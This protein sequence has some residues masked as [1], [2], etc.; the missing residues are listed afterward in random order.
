MRNIWPILK[1][2]AVI[3]LRLAAIVFVVHLASAAYL[4]HLS[5]GNPAAAAYPLMKGDPE[6]YAALARNLLEHGVFSDSDSLV[7]SRAWPPAY[8]A[9]L[10][11]SLWATGS[12]LPVVALQIALACA[13]AAL[14]FRMALSLAPPRWAFAAALLF[15]AEPSFVLSN[16]LLLT[17]GL[18]ASLL[19]CAVYL[20]LFAD[21]RGRE[22][23]RWVFAGAFLGALTLLRPIAEFLIP[24][25]AVFML[26]E[27]FLLR[28]SGVRRAALHAIALL[29][30]AALVLAP[31][32]MRNQRL[33]GNAEIAHVGA[34]NLLHYNAREFLQWQRMETWSPVAALRAARSPADPAL[35]ADVDAELARM[36]PEGGA[37][38]DY[39]GALAAR[40]ILARPFAYAYFHIVNTAPF[41]VG[42]G[43]AAYAQAARQIGTESGFYAPTSAALFAAA[44][45]AA[46][47][48]WGGA[49]RRA[50]PL[51]PVIL[52]MLFWSAAA[53]LAAWGAWRLRRDSRAAA[54][55]LIVL[56]FALITGPVAIPRY[57]LP[58]EPFLLALAAAG[59]SALAARRKR[60]H[61][62]QNSFRSQYSFLRSGRARSTNVN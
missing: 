38:A 45:E 41:F 25:V 5:A 27:A 17:D 60:D 61:A 24:A 4:S 11:A 16:T 2:D 46:R 39:E 7:P 18:F 34:S 30:A 15:G 6:T 53:F 48:E 8:P 42:S 59:A 10:A 51:A 28:R 3:A 49:A 20:M 23:L 31:W 29:A 22:L 58:A 9:L 62:L 47:G 26:A 57:R 37:A 12:F 36:T 44:E 55:A 33:F 50:A 54:F 1:C 19:V 14:A 40:I 32:T 56:Y 52:E 43:I 21:M 13:A 35:L